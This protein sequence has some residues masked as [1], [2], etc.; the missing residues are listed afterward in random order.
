MM[1]MNSDEGER[2]SWPVQFLQHY[3]PDA[4]VP[5]APAAPEWPEFPSLEASELAAVSKLPEEIWRAIL[6]FLPK[7]YFILEALERGKKFKNNADLRI[8]KDV[9]LNK[10]AGGEQIPK[11][12]ILR[13]IHGN[14]SSLADEACHKFSRMNLRGFIIFVDASSTMVELGSPVE[15]YRDALP[16]RLNGLSQ[17]RS[18]NI[19]DIFLNHQVCTLAELMQYTGLQASSASR[20]TSKM[21]K[22]GLLRKTGR[23]SYAMQEAFLREYVVRMLKQLY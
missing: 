14:D 22:L 15:F 5:A 8:A 13:T 16:S 10:L 20:Y 12:L 4:D 6:L 21:V 3:V 11:E 2:V 23:G 7:D 9:I 19:L 1:D 18:G 17:A